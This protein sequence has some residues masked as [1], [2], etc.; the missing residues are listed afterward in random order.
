M[1][2]R[3]GPHTTAD[4]AGRYRDDDE[5]RRWRALDPIERYRAWLLASGHADDAFVAEC[6][7]AAE[8]E[9]TRIR[10]DVIADRAAAR[11]VDVRL[12]V[13]RIHPEPFLRERTEARRRC[14]R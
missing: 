7:A 10:A 4:D 5:V 6:D 9:V 13:R 3:V 1:T 14:L 2:Y 8:A 12:D 11:R